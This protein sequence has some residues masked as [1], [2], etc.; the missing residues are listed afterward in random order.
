MALRS[1]AAKS[2]PE[3]DLRRFVSR[4]GPADQKLFRSVRTAVRKRL[5]TAT[6][7]AYDYTRNVVVSYSP[8]ENGIDGIVAISA[9]TGDMRLYLLEG[10]ATQARFIRV[11]AASRLAHPDVEA[12]IVA[13]IS[14]ARV[15]LPTKGRGTLVIRTDSEKKKPRGRAAK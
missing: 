7:L 15:P 4:L 2:S 9:R 5:P 14:R 12:L 3:A 10:K 11:E 1:I 8:T 6:E 13:A